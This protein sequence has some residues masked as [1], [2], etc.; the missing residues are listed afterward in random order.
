[1]NVTKRAI[2]LVSILVISISV[3]SQPLSIKTLMKVYN[4]KNV[5]QA[6]QLIS[7]DKNLAY[8]SYIA[9]EMGD[10]IIVIRIG[11]DSLIAKK[12]RGVI[13]VLCHVLRDE[14]VF[15]DLKL[16][17]SQFLKPIETATAESLGTKRLHYVYGLTKPVKRGDPEIIV[18]KCTVID[19][20]QVYYEFT[21]FPSR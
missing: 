21:I 6:F 9:D 1:M 5:T 16:Q 13:V 18:S 17:A 14:A 20:G 15:K 8:R 2:L 10:S 3:L 4:S 7:K 11:N 12:Q 19:T